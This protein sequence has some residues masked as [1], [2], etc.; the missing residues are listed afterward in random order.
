VVIG[1]GIVATGAYHWVQSYAHSWS[2]TA[3]S[4]C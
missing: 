3:A 1:A 2:M 4:G